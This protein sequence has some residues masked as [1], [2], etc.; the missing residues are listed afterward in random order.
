[1]EHACTEFSTEYSGSFTMPF[2]IL[3]MKCKNMLTLHCRMNRV[4]I[5]HSVGVKRGGGGLV[6]L[7]WFLC[8]TTFAFDRMDLWSGRKK[9]P[10]S[11]C[12]RENWRPTCAPINKIASTQTHTE[13]KG[14]KTKQG[15]A[16]RT[17]SSANTTFYTIRLLKRAVIYVS[18][19]TAT[20][21]K[22]QYML[23]TIN[24]A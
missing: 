23:S 8:C 19:D 13:R 24:N 6:Q 5:W 1:M 4:Q 2:L 22:T 21:S 18:I 3:L 11:C 7:G 9:N 10:S 14:E 15:S 16:Q 17:Q 12:A 20:S